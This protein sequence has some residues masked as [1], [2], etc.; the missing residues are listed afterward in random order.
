M[1]QLA[2]AGWSSPGGRLHEPLQEAQG[3]VAVARTQARVD[4]ASRLAD[5]V[6]ALMCQE[7]R[8]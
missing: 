2:C 5:L 8:A 4:A 7:A 3:A 1:G 6:E